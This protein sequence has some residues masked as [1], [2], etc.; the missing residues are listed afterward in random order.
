MKH[1]LLTKSSFAVLALL[2]AATVTAGDVEIGTVNRNGMEVTAVYIQP[3]TMEPMMAGMGQAADI[4]L[5][6]DIHALKDNQHGFGEGDWIPYLDISITITKYGADWSVTGALM[7]M[8][9]ADGPHYA[10]NIKLDGAGKY[11]LSY[12]IKPPAYSAF[13][14]HTDKETGVPEWWAPFDLEWDFTYVGVGK[15]G[16]Y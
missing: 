9:A 15:K 3:V 8:I 2:L 12:H 5:E 13:H 6:A 10:D 16:G 4:H 14:R 7:P 1:S 11:H